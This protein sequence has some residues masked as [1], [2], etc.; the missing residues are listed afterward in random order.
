MPITSLTW[1]C[2][3]LI[4]ELSSNLT[5]DQVNA[6][7]FA[8][9]LQ[10]IGMIAD[11]R[12]DCCI[13]TYLCTILWI[14]REANNGQIIQYVPGGIFL[15]K[16]RY[17]YNCRVVKGYSCFLIE[18]KKFPIRFFKNT[19]YSRN[20]PDDRSIIFLYFYANLKYSAI[21][22][23]FW[24]YIYIIKIKHAFLSVCPSVNILHFLLFNEKYKCY[25]KNNDWIRLEKF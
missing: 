9:S 21:D 7:F 19:A 17:Y 18:T 12:A 14:E 22:L 13:E 16:F 24:A 3:V 11:D 23:K 10:R 8:R 4:F 6:S 15:I 2:S 25:R 20:K 5:R 1:R